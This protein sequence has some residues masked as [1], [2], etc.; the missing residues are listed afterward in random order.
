MT[1]RT[2]PDTE[3]FREQMQVYRESFRLTAQYQEAGLQVT[4][5]GPEMSLDPGE[6]Y[7][8]LPDEVTAVFDFMKNNLAAIMNENKEKINELLDLTAKMYKRFE[9]EIDET[10]WDLMDEDV[11]AETLEYLHSLLTRSAREIGVMLEEHDVDTLATAE[12]DEKLRKR[13]QALLTGIN[14]LLYALDNKS[15]SE[16]EKQ[17]IDKML[18][19]LD[20][21]FIDTG[22]VTEDDTRIDTP[23][24]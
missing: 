14:K 11:E 20:R 9:K 7:E 2:A 10:I 8:Q 1:A 3:A 5:Q 15:I 24:V 18:A 23:I 6:V 16:S 21:G 4:K 13:V 22:E 19:R 12:M 17:E